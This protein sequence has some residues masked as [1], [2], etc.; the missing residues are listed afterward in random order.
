[1]AQKTSLND[2]LLPTLDI[3]LKEAE[4]MGFPSID[5]KRISESDVR[6]NSV[7]KNTQKRGAID[8]IDFKAEYDS[9]IFRSKKPN[10]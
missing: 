3:P 4:L 10:L 1:M 7:R 2:L 8:M 6:S 5:I 9:N